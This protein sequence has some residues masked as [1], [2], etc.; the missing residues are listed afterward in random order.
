MSTYEA[1]RDYI[2]KELF[3]GNPPD[4]FDDTYDLIESGYMDSISMMA[5]FSYLE[6]QHDIE[7]GI[8]DI[9]PEN[10]NSLST[11]LAFADKQTSS[12]SAG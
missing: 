2:T 4:E 11:L 10:F 9:V 5:L 3:K 6:Q 8:N 7:F 12:Q 1:L